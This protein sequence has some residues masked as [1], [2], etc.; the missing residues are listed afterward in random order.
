ME[1]LEKTKPTKEAFEPE[2]KRAIQEAKA[3]LGDYKL[4]SSDKYDVPES[5]RMNVSKKRKH[6]FLLEDF[7]FNAKMKFNN[8]IISLKTRKS[9]II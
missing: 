2:S 9:N 5:Q 6:M 3:T 8:E 1:D 7:I 4:K